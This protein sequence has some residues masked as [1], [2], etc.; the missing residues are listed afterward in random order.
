M[1]DTEFPDRSW[2]E[3]DGRAAV[4]FRELADA[5]ERVVAVASPGDGAVAYINPFTERSTGIPASEVVGRSFADRLIPGEDREAFEAASRRSS[6][7]GVAVDLDG[8]IRRRDGSLRMIRWGL[9][10]IAGPDGVS[11][12]LI[13]GRDVTDVGRAEQRLLQ[14]ERMAAIG[15]VSAGLAHESRNALQRSQACL[16][17]LALKVEDRP[18]AVD[19]IGRIQ[20]AQ[21]DL[22]RLYEDVREFAAPIHLELRPCRLSDVWRRAWEKLD[23]ARMGRDVRFEEAGEVLSLECT[24]DAFRLEQ[25]FANLFDNSLAA[26]TDPAKVT[27]DAS[28]A[29]LDG[30]DGL[31]VVVRDDGP[32]LTSEQRARFFDAFFTTKTRG[33]GLGTAIV[34]RIIEA[35]GGRVEVGAAHPRGAE[36]VLT[37]PRGRGDDA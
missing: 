4:A 15:Q 1:A 5:V 31:R 27:V 11:A 16:E 21:D 6:R 23:R 30:R 26:S 8:M 29:R 17:M 24:A 33:T 14:A 36:V 10:P 32:G 18:D 13:V 34:K 37:I 28:L 20:Q 7:S 35:H 2:V 3:A 12:L 22:H 19:L 9:R 25:V